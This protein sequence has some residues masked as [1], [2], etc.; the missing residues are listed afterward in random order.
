MLTFER[1]RVVKGVKGEDGE[2]PAKLG[3]ESGTRNLDGEHGAFAQVALHRNLAAVTFGNH[4]ADHESETCSLVL[5]HFSAGDLAVFLKQLA[6][7]VGRY[8][9]AIVFNP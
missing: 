8:S 4:L 6:D 9:L 5:R 1:R 7:L 2:N 3:I